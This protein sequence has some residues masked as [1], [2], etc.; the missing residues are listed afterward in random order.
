MRVS[1]TPQM[2]ADL[3]RSAGFDFALERCELLAP[4]LDWLLAQGDLLT[5]LGLETEESVLTLRPDTAV[6]RVKREPEHG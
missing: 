2:V 5:G 6:S 1:C 4:Q 3:A